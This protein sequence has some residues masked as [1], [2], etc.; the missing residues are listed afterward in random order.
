M[1]TVPASF[2]AS[3]RELTRE[4]ALAAGLPED[5]VLLEEPQAA[6]YAWLADRGDRWRRLLEA[7]R[8]AAGLRRRRRHD[9]PDAG[10][11]GRGERRTGPAAAWPSA[12]TCWSAATTWTWPWPT[13]WPAGS[14]RRA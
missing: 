9:R 13:T 7:G 11:R 10:R 12:I 14:P 4:A 3:A 5:L 8:H 6:V 2:D 1:L